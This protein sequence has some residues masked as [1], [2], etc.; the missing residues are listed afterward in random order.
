MCNVEYKKSII[1][2]TLAS[3]KL[4][5]DDRIKSIEQSAAADAAAAATVAMTSAATAPPAQ[6]E[7]TAVSGSGSKS[8]IYSLFRRMSSSTSSKK[9]KDSSAKKSSLT[10]TQELK[11][12]ED[13]DH[14]HREVDDHHQHNQ[15]EDELADEETEAE[16]EMII[17]NAEM[18][19][20]EKAS[21]L[22]GKIDRSV[23]VLD[24]L[25]QELNR[26][27]LSYNNLLLSFYAN[28]QLLQR[29]F[30]LVQ[31]KLNQNE[32]VAAK[33]NVAS[34][35]E[36][37]KLADELEK[38]KNFQLKISSY[39]PFI[40]NMCN[41]YTNVMQELQQ[42]CAATTTG[43]GDDT[44]DVDET[45][46]TLATSSTT[47]RTRALG[48]ITAKYEDL[49][50]RWSNLQNQLQENYLHLYSLIESSGAD[51]FI[52]LADSVQ[53]PWQRAVSA[54]NKIPYYIK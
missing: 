34:Q 54:N 13:G 37:D 38:V 7:P 3:A 25:W 19:A 42:A 20:T 15:H 27:S 51:I 46:A 45:T 32:Q 26:R 29:S 31:Q 39:Q 41:H 17:N 50:L 6:P 40:D 9:K 18:S 33:M 23:Q 35:I 22:V 49:N 2:S 30:E 24:R 4:Y 47:A 10:S 5:Y 44:N 48:N 28:L 12:K 52:K 53:A 21:L 43:G 36:S 11:I 14:Q 8:Q 16:L 1:E